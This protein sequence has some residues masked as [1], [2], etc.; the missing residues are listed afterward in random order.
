MRQLRSEEIEVVAKAQISLEE[1]LKRKLTE[2]EQRAFHG[3]AI[4]MTDC[5]DCLEAEHASFGDETHLSK[6]QLTAAQDEITLL[7]AQLKEHEDKGLAIYGRKIDVLNG[8]VRVLKAKLAKAVEQRNSEA[9]EVI[10]LKGM[11]NFNEFDLAL[12]IRVYNEELS[13][14]TLETIKKGS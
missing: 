14:I 1:E 4:S 13:R 5:V 8:T 6:S 9:K 10:E 11:E 12:V 3:G 2:S 7:K